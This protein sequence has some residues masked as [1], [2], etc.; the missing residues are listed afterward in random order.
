MSVSVSVLA[1]APHIKYSPGISVGRFEQLY[2]HFFRSGK[3][4]A[5]DAAQGVWQILAQQGQKI[6]KEGKTLETPEEN[7]AKLTQQAKTFLEARLPVLRA[8]QIA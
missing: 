1:S 4:T 8:L 3:K 7:V 6:I 5:A 2:L